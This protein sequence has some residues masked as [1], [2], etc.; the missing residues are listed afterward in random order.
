MPGKDVVI[1]TTGGINIPQ[2][3]IFCFVHMTV[4]FPSN[5][6]LQKYNTI[7]Y[8]IQNTIQRT[9]IGT[10]PDTTDDTETEKEGKHLTH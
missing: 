3:E 2:R 9:H 7:Q 5:V 8:K 10:I 4:A 1:C 6:N